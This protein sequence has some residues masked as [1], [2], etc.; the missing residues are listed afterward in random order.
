MPKF[1][2]KLIVMTQYVTNERFT[3]FG[4]GYVNRKGVAV[5][6]ARPKMTVDVAYIYYYIKEGWSAKATEELR[7]MIPAS[8]NDEQQTFK[9]LNF[10][11]VTFAG[12]FSYRNGGHLIERSPFMVLDVDHLGSEAEAR[13]VQQLFVADREVETALCFLSPR[14]EGVKWVVRLPEW[15]LCLPTYREQFQQMQKYVAFT[16]GIS[17]DDG[18]DVNRTCY[19]PYDPQCFVNEKYLQ[20]TLYKH[21]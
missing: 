16:H 10:E 4:V 17:I 13:R 6:A 3:M 18:K 9:K 1:V 2:S 19:L 15:C 12:R 14:G 7:R 20:N 11:T 21:E 8:N 5:L